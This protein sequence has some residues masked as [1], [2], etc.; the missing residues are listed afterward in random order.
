MESL[1]FNVLESPSNRAVPDRDQTPEKVWVNPLP[2]LSVPPL[3]VIASP[4]PPTF[5]VKVAVAAVFVIETLPV[6]VNPAMF[7]AIVHAMT[8]LD[9]P[10]VNVPLFVKSPVNVN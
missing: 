5:P 6:V 10:A 3:P 1:N 4:A 9:A 7:C 2:S 8:I